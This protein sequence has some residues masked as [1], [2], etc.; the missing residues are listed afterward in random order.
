MAEAA[1]ASMT[2]VDWVKGL[3]PAINSVVTVVVTA[4]VTFA[5]TM[6]VQWALIKPAPI[7]AADPPRPPVVNLGPAMDRLRV[8]EGEVGKLQEELAAHRKEFAARLGLRPAPV[9]AAEKK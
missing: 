6:A 8:I 2:W 5:S 9:K 3:M 7:P 1:S 4:L